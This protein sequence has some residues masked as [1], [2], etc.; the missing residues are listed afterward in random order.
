MWEVPFQNL[1]VWWGGGNVSYMESLFAQSRTIYHEAIGA[2]YHPQDCE[3][4]AGA[5]EDWVAF[6][7]NAADHNHWVTT[8]GRLIDWWSDRASFSVDMDRSGKGLSLSFSGPEGVT[9]MLPMTTAKGTLSLDQSDYREASIIGMSYR[10][11]RV[12]S[13]ESLDISWE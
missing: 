6:L 1:P 8:M 9:L 2:L 7:R 10:L 3:N 4:C 11:V 13:G 12:E 5:Y